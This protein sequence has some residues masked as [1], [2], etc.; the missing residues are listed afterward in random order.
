MP[1]SVDD[2]FRDEAL[3][4]L[5]K[6]TGDQASGFREQQLEVIHRL[7]EE[8]QRVLLVERTGWGKSAGYFIA[9]RMLRDRGAGPTLLISPL[10]ALMRNQIEAAVPMGVRAVTINSENR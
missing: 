8:R 5:R 9:T 7:V 4:H 1:Y 6:L 3:G 2:A 10:L